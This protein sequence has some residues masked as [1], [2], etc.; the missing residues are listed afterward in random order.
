[1]PEIA[2]LPL[3]RPKSLCS[4]SPSQPPPVRVQRRDRGRVCGDGRRPLDGVDLREQRC[5]DQAARWNSVS[6]SKSGCACGEHVADAVVL[7]ARTAPAACRARARSPVAGSGS[8]AGSSGIGGSPSTRRSLPPSWLRRNCCSLRAV[9]VDLRAVPPVRHD[10]DVCRRLVRAAAGAVGSS[11]V[12]ITWSGGVGQ[13][14]SGLERDDPRVV[15]RARAV[16]EP[17][18]DH[19]L[20]PGGDQRVACRRGDELVARH[21]PPAD[22]ARVRFEHLVAVG[23]G[24]FERDVAP[25]PGAGHAH[26]GMLEVVPAAVADCAR[27]RNFSSYVRRPA[28][29]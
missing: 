13:S 21:Q 4:F 8:V 23:P 27:C 20:Q 14:S 11:G 7:L 18:V 12:R 17:V 10:V 5:V 29:D 3:S 26:L 25:E 15:G 2:S 19:E 16:P 22:V 9:A 1:M 6:S 28:R 24:V